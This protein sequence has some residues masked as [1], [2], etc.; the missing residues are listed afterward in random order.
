MSGDAG[1]DAEVEEALLEHYNMDCEELSQHALY[2]RAKRLCQRTD[3]GK[4]QVQKMF[5]SS[6]WK[7]QR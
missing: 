3:R 6:G 5:I 2:M 7:A 1:G 4:L